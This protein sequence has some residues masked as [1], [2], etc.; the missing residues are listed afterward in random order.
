M[1]YYKVNFISN[2][3]EEISTDDDGFRRLLARARNY[4]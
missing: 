4:L 2:Y 3:D 1:D